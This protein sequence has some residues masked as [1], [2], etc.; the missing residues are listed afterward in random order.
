[1]YKSESCKGCPV[2][3]LCTKTQHR[4]RELHINKQ[5]EKSRGETLRLLQTE[6]GKELRKRRG[7]EVE[8]VLGDGK[9]NQGFKRFRLRGMLKVRAEMGLHLISYNLRKIW[10]Q[11]LKP[12][13]A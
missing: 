2:K 5:L 4:H 13:P 7:N 10:K 11:G 1:M 12:L 3:G 8:T 6:K 9:Y